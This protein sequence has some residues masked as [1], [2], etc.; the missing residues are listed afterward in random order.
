MRVCVRRGGGGGVYSSS[1]LHGNNSAG[2]Q[3]PSL[4]RSLLI[5]AV[6]GCARSC[7]SSPTSPS[8]RT[9]RPALAGPPP[10]MVAL[11]I[12]GGAPPP[13]P[14]QREEAARA[15]T[16]HRLSGGTAAE[17]LHTEPD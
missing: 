15:D 6:D 16:L 12:A 3:L 11:V 5:A 9:H 8:T 4:Y 2:E 13:P 1:L 10:A 7:G 17:E 14:P